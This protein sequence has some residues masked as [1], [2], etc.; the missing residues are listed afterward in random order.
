MIA[1]RSSFLIAAAAVASATLT[2]SAGAHT[3]D[4]RT[5]PS[6]EIVGA[7]P[8]DFAGEAVAAG[9]DVNGDH[10]DDVLVAAPSA[11]APGRKDAGA[12]YV[13]FG[14]R[15]TA[16]AIKAHPSARI[17]LDGPAQ[18]FRILGPGLSTNA[19]ASVAGAGD[20]DGDGLDD[21][22][23][24]VPDDGPVVGQ[25]RPTP[26]AV[27]AGAAYLVFGRRAGTTVDLAHLGNAG[28]KIDG[29]TVDRDQLG[30]SVAGGRDVDG[31]GRP[32]VVVTDAPTLPELALPLTAPPTLRSS[33]Y[34]I[35]GATLHRGEELHID[36]PGVAGSRLDGNNLGP[37]SLAA[38]M[39]GDG[40]AEV[41]AADNEGSTLH[42]RARVAFGRPAGSP[43]LDLAQLGD[44]GFSLVDSRPPFQWM[45]VQGGGDV[46]G[47]GRGDL[48]ATSYVRLAHHRYAGIAAVVFGAPSADPVL[49]NRP[50]PR[51]LE[52][53]GPSVPMLKMPPIPGAAAPK[54]PNYIVGP[55]PVQAVGIVGDT[56]GDGLDD[57]LAGGFASP[58]GRVGA[59][60]AFLFRGRHTPGRIR[61]SGGATDGRTVRIDGAYA[62]DTFGSAA[63]PAGDF[64]GDGRPDLLVSGASSTRNGRLRAGAAWVLTNVRP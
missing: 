7:R 48:V 9:G 29:A 23:V 41:V 4:L 19:G 54:R 61:L 20:V 42:E 26:G 3:I 47:D 34:V 50:G 38:D 45:L 57:L 56:D 27:H 14:R 5:Q 46:N 37:V 1:S 16:R 51:L 58:H 63:S 44:G 24:G 17:A 64:D 55:T 33:A 59:G 43:P 30:M 25:P 35:S 39:N 12:V 60:S 18:G 28:V 13:V 6:F 40:R 53:V 11:D 15:R 22:I 49:I 10:I 36:A 21:V 52:A 2:A 32:D 8:I 31:D 62:G